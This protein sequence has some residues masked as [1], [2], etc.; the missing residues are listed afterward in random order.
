VGVSREGVDRGCQGFCGGESIVRVLYQAAHDD[1]V[2]RRR[3][4]RIVMRR[5]RRGAGNDLRAD[6]ADRIATEGPNAGRHLVENDT[7][8]EKVGTAVLQMTENLF[9]G[10]IGRSSQQISAAGGLRRKAGNAEVAQLH[11]MLGSNENIGGFHV[12]MNDF[13]AMGLAQ[14]C[15][16]IARP[17]G[18]ARKRQRAGVEKRL[19][20]FALNIFH[21]E[22]R[23]A[24]LVGADI[25]EGHDV[26]M[27]EAA[28]DL[29]FAEEL[30]LEIAGA[31]TSKQGF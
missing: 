6:G 11:L 20:R 12:A 28:N 3:Q 22:I 31:K 1:L 4:R 13:G 17:H 27:R 8:R 23:R 18:Y 5:R 15:G 19:Q 21:D 29:G 9:R 14:C 16:K 10:K 24:V 26:G 7:Q 2:K 30:L 25:E